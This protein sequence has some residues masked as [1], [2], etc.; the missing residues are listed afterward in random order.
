MRTRKEIENGITWSRVGGPYQDDMNLAANL[1]LENVMQNQGL[2]IEVLL[3][4]RDLLDPTA[5]IEP[6]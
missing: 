5:V 2:L 6:K 1:N 3:D 4:I